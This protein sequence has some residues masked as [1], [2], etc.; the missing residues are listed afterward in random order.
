MKSRILT[1]K[2]STL[3]TLHPKKLYITKHVTK[4]EGYYQHLFENRQ[5]GNKKIDSHAQEPTKNFP[6]H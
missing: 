1:R 5:I 4:K 3:K 6:D 2:E